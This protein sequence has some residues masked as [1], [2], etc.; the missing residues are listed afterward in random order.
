MELWQ[1]LLFG[2]VG[3]ALP[4]LIRVAKAGGSLGFLT[5]SFLVSFVALIVVGAIAAYIAE[6]IAGAD[7]STVLSA[8]TAGFGGPEVISRLGKKSDDSAADARA[9]GSSSV[10]LRE[11]WAI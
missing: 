4:D 9:T 5:K 10:R 1:V 11:W 2:A 6:Q 8:L 3:G 7:K